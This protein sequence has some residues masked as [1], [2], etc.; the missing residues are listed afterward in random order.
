MPAD[1][2]ACSLR[3]PKHAPRAV[4]D[5]TR[6]RAL[7]EPGMSC[8]SDDRG[9]SRVSQPDRE[10]ARGLEALIFR[11]YMKLGLPLRY[12]TSHQSLPRTTRRCVGAAQASVPHPPALFAALELQH[13]QLA[14]GRGG[15]PQP[16]TDRCD[17]VENRMTGEATTTL[18][19]IVHGEQKH[20]VGR[21]G[22]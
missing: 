8:G 10:F 21:G 19:R 15:L 3:L 17:P 7:A 5:S 13:Q 12:A 14:S 11:P 1:D 18:T 20:G 2:P 9:A 4:H 6:S 16:R 22:T